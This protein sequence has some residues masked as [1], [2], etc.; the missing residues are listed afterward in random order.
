MQRVG[1]KDNHFTG[2]ESAVRGNEGNKSDLLGHG[3]RGR[4]VSRLHRRL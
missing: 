2:V 4:S 1:S 3:D